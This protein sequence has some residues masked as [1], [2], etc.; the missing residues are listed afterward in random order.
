[1]NSTPH[2]QLDGFIVAPI[3]YHEQAR[4]TNKRCEHLSSGP[5][6][7][8]SIDTAILVRAFDQI[9]VE[10]CGSMSTPCF[11]CGTVIGRVPVKAIH[12]L[13]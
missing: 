7:G 3:F 5:R 1:M 6:R 11:A 2:P 10:I 4:N 12:Y 13:A 9:Y 8:T